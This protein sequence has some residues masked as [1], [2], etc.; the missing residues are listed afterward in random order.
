MC[1]DECVVDVDVH[2]D[3]DVDVD[4]MHVRFPSFISPHFT[5]PIVSEN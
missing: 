1:S 5:I 2:V 3:V 4:T